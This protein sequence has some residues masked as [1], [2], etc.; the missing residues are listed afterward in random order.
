MFSCY[1]LDIHFCM[2]I[3][4]L[5][6]KTQTHIHV[7]SHLYINGEM[8]DGAPHLGVVDMLLLT[9][10]SLPLLAFTP[11]SDAKQLEFSEDRG[12]KFIKD[13]IRSIKSKNLKDTGVQEHVP[14]GYV[15]VDNN[16]EELKNN[17]AAIKNTSEALPSDLPNCALS[18]GADLK[19]KKDIHQVHIAVKIRPETVDGVGYLLQENAAGGIPEKE[20][21]WYAGRRYNSSK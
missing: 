14:D 18:S 11:T 20:E 8:Y 21:V 6:P 3:S 12:P 2:N 16:V 7:R 10:F 13:D 5:C 4:S 17:L 1:A 15:A 9:L 19:E